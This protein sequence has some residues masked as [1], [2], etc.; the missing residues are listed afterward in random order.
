MWTT[1]ERASWFQCNWPVQ[2]QEPSVRVG[3]HQAVSWGLVPVGL[4][5]SDADDS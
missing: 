4:E 2:L 3:L 1:R 5:W